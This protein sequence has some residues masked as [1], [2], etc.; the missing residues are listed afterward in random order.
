VFEI[1]QLLL[2]ILKL[3]DYTGNLFTCRFQLG[4]GT[5]VGKRKREKEAVEV[6]PILVSQVSWSS[7]CNTQ[8]TAFQALLRNQSQQLHNVQNYT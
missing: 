5:F 3:G 4:F 8:P 7:L 1:D 6:N 2:S